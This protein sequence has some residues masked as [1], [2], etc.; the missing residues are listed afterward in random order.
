MIFTSFGL[1]ISFLGLWN[2]GSG[3]FL[4]QR[5]LQEGK[6]EAVRAARR[7]AGRCLH[8]VVVR[9]GEGEAPWEAESFQASPCALRAAGTANCQCPAHLCEIHTSDGTHGGGD[10]SQETVHI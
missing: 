7:E 8:S 1:A 4:E 6:R 10:L 9:A 3:D 2:R 5:K